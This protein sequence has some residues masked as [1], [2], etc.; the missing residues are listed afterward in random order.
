MAGSKTNFL[1]NEILD[2]NLKALSYTGPATVF[3]ALFTASPT[4]TGSMA[5]EVTNAN[6]Y[7][8]TAVTFDA[9][10]GGATANSADVTFPQATGSWGT[11]SDWMCV[12]SGTHGAGNG[13][14]YG[15]V[16]TAK[17]IA[18]S[19]TAVFEAGDIDIAED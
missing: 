19:D 8:R 1:E 4:E 11:V 16:N 13:L 6:A 5:S 3:L 12:D 15:N 14:Y 2:N 10:V 18:A 17:A 7:A 9:A